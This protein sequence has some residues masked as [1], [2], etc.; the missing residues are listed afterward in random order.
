MGRAGHSAQRVS[1]VSTGSRIEP[2]SWS[3]RGSPQRLVQDLAGL[4]LVL[5]LLLLVRNGGGFL[6]KARPLGKDA[7][8][9]DS[10]RVAVLALEKNM[11]V[12]PS[13]K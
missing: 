8:Q 2:A 1:A 7:M 13:L 4:N 5:L 3:G 9:Q 11:V 12:S 6:E 10:R